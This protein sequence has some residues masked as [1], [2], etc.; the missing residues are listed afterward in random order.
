MNKITL[1]SNIR[2]IY[3]HPIG[4]D[5]LE[6]LLMQMGMSADILKKPLISCL[7]LKQVK[8]LFGKKLGYEF[9]NVIINLLNSESNKPD[10]NPVDSIPKWWKEAVFY[11]VYPRSFMDS[12][13][14]GIG[15]IAGITSKLD[16]LK[17]LSVDAIWLCPIYDSP[18][19]DN[20][21]DI[22]DY[23]SILPEYGTMEDFDM[24][25]NGIHERGMK[26]IMDLVVN[27]TSDEHPWFIKAL[28][29]ENSPYRDFYFFRKTNDGNPPNN[30]TSFFGGSAW[31]YYKEQDVWALHLFSKKQMDLNWENP[32]LRNAIYDM[33]KWWLNKGVDG[34]RLDVI[35]YI[36]KQEN[37]PDGNEFIGSLMG[38]TGIEHYFYGPKLHEYLRELHMESFEPYRAFSVGETPGVGQMMGR[39]ITDTCRNELDLIFSFDHLETPGHTRFDKYIYD[40]NYLKKFY[41]NRLNADYGHGWHTL[42]FDNHDNPRMLSKICPDGRYRNEL[43]KLLGVLKLTQRGTPFIYQG[44][45]I[46]AVNKKFN[47]IDELRDVESINFYN[48]LIKTNSRNEAFT[49]VLSGTRDHARTPMQWED[50]PNGG[51]TTSVPWIS[52]DGDEKLYNTANQIEDQNSV[53]NFYKKL[54]L[55]RRSSKVLIYGETKYI[56]L[57]DKDIYRYI[58]YLKNRQTDDKNIA[59]YI[60]CNLSSTAKKIKNTK[61]NGKVLLSNYKDNTTD[62]LRPYEVRIYKLRFCAKN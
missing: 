52:C 31:N 56:S 58:R 36:S 24:L 25:L 59:Y 53:W 26:L 13:G 45:E 22:R 20:G 42:F 15:D 55:L 11:Q 50:K 51:F 37:L 34:F 60:E 38:Y 41:V 40:L 1:N 29:D 4:H 17:S 49:K 62:I 32:M 39:L 33:V 43:A 8:A 48:E 47:S 28:N 57:K 16:Y 27:H 61:F 7:K 3:E 2:D 44:E 14:D 12:D 46:G 19:D 21:Y 9:F 6:R 18:N 30:W 10:D 35:N 54:I 23:Y 5:I